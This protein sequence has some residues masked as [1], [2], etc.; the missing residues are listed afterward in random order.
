[1]NA[2]EKK[3][4]DLVVFRIRSRSS[5]CTEC[6]EDIPSG[7]LLRKEGE[8]G[9]CLGCA[10]MDHLVFLPSG[11]P[12]LTRR[13]SKASRLRAVV[14]EWSRSRKR[15][16]RQGVLVE[17]AAIAKAEEECLSDAELRERRRERA[18]ERREGL[19][20]RFIDEF[21]RR[22]RERY[23]AAPGNAGQTIAEHACRKY[24]GRVGRSAAAKEFDVEAIDLAVRAH[25][26]HRHTRYDG[27]LA[28]GLERHEARAAIR[29]ELEL[30]L[31]TWREG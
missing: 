21:A 19:D 12:A 28:E 25:V 24:S 11:D 30:E 20:R 14:V 4:D 18:E 26:R 13:A 27:L 1:M 31:A 8:K 6:S 2:Q 29:V 16:E 10:D 5:S 7:G 15:Y 9:L 22:I 3:P 17:E 23:P